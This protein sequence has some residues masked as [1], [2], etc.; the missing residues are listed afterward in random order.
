MGINTRSVPLK[1]N[2]PHALAPVK[3]AF[4]HPG[5]VVP[6]DNGGQA[7]AVFEQIGCKAYNAVA[8]CDIG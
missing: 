2:A 6:Y 3:H 1:L 7:G 8:N 4:F 5:D